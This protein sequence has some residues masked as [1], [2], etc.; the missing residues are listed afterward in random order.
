MAKVLIS[1]SHMAKV[2]SSFSKWTKIHA[3][4]AR[5]KGISSKIAQIDSRA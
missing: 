4:T 5:R 1:I 2:L 3:T